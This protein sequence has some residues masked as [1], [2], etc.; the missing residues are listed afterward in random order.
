MLLPGCHGERHGVERCNPKR[1]GGI[2]EF[3]LI[4][5]ASLL[6]V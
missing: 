5:P 2:L 1:A 4:D 6:R 3:E